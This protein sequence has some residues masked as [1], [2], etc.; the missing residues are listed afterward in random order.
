MRLTVTSVPVDAVPW[1]D[2]D[3]RPGRSVFCTRGWLRHLER[4]QGVEP[5]VGRVLLDGRELGWFTGATGRRAG[6]PMLGA[7]LPGWGTSYMG[8]DWDDPLDP[9]VLPAALAAVRRWSIQELR[10]AHTEVL[11]RVD[12]LTLEIPP[13]MTCGLFH[14]YERTLVD[15]DTMLA[16]MSTNARRNIARSV[17]RGVVIEAVEPA[18]A[19]GFADE[20]FAQVRDAFLRRGVRPTF[21][22][23][24]VRHLLDAMLT[25]GHLLAL[26]ALTP[27]GRPAGTALSA[28]VPG[29]RAVFLTGAADPGMLDI[30][31]N[32]ALMWEAMRRW[33][34]RGCDVFDFGGGGT[35]KL[36]FGCRPVDS[37]W[38]RSSV[39]PGAEVLRTGAR[40]AHRRAHH[41]GDRAQAL[42]TLGADTASGVSRRD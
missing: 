5:A 25:D 29:G 33:R 11:V 6:V 39:L 22:V 27:E 34:D 21:D 30:R 32:E 31:P 8:F 16:G 4:S 1:D 15:D 35:Y 10:C 24:R 7:P 18:G 13:G 17:R 40:R 42:R 19:S 36:K 37:A 38:L 14:S 41:L 3:T 26:R 2:L 12:P 9:R 28:G 20:C 23:D